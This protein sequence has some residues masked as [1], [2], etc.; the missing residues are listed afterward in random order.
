MLVL[1]QLRFLV[2]P[3]YCLGLN[4]HYLSG[5]HIPIAPSLDEM[6]GFDGVFRPCFGFNRRIGCQKLPAD[7]AAGERGE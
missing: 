3:Q 7:G 1:I 2:I 5:A 4:T 6:I